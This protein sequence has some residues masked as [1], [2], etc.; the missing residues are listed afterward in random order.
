MISNTFLHL[1]FLKEMLSIC[2]TTRNML[3]IIIMMDQLILVTIMTITITIIFQVAKILECHICKMINTREPLM[4]LEFNQILIQVFNG[5]LEHFRKITEEI[6]KWISNGRVQIQAIYRLVYQM[7]IG[8]ILIIQEK[9]KLQQCLVKP[10]M[11]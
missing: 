9:R 3:N 2:M 8:G 4:N 1:H 6:M 5:F 10:L 7:E 11:T